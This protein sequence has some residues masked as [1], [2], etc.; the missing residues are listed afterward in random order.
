MLILMIQALG[1]KFLRD[2]MSKKRAVSK[3]LFSNLFS[4]DFTPDG[5]RAFRCLSTL[6]RYMSGGREYIGQMCR[7]F[8][9]VATAHSFPK[10][11]KHVP[12]GRNRDTPCVRI[13]LEYGLPTPMLG[14]IPTTYRQYLSSIFEYPV[15]PKPPEFHEQ[16]RHPIR[17]NQLTSPLIPILLCETASGSFLLHLRKQLPESTTAGVPFCRSN[18]HGFFHMSTVHVRHVDP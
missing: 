10:H 3:R 8:P 4:S 18:R 9:F 7:S 1:V 12:N 16:Q 13:M 14:H 15:R 17:K 11:P 2:G 5:R 6:I